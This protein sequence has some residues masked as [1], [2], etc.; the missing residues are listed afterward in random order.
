[1]TVSQHHLLFFDPYRNTEGQ[2]VLLS[3]PHLKAQPRL[4]HAFALPVPDIQRPVARDRP[5]RALMFVPA[6]ADAAH[7]SSFLSK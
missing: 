1:M 5:L 2:C 3:P 6:A 7:D 4:H